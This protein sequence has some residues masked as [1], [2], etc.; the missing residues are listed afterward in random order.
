MIRHIVFFS[1]RDKA[2][3]PTIERELG[4]LGTIPASAHF[5]V[6][7]NAHLDDW[8]AEVDLVVYAEFEDEAA[9]RA[10]KAHPTYAEITA[11]VRPMRDLR[12]AADYQTNASIER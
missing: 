7:R 1:A 4:I 8:S 11:R 5:E 9:F 12:F 2:D 3:L 6:T 10:Y